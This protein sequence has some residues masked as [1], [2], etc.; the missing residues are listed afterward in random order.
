M[1]ISAFLMSISMV[2]LG[3]TIQY[4]DFLV[5][6]KSL[7]SF[8]TNIEFLNSTKE[9]YAQGISSNSSVESN[10]EEYDWVNVQ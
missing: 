6:Q 7:K 8:N 5:Q 3:L 1:V 10:D 9:Y 4:K 2:S